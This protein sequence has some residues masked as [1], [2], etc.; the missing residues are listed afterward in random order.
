M[1]NLF[2][3]AVI[4]WVAIPLAAWGDIVQPSGSGNWVGGWTP[5]NGGTYYWDHQSFDGTQCNVGY[6][7]IGQAGAPG[8]PCGSVVPANALPLN[9]AP[10]NIPFWAAN[11]AGSVPV[12][13]FYFSPSNP[14]H[15]VQLEVEIAGYASSNQ[16]YIYFRNGDPS[17]LVFDGSDSA[18]KT[19]SLT[20]TGDFGFYLAAMGTGPDYY[21]ESSKNTSDGSAQ[22]FALFREKPVGTAGYSV[23]D[24]WLGIEDMP[25]DSVHDRDY[26]DMLVRISA[27]PEPGSIVLLGTCLLCAGPIA[28]RIRRRS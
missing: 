26:Q 6:V 8:S 10:G 14:D 4:L 3:A 2:W 15:T 16:L 11:A 20:I 18:P 19:V 22:H 21:T 27:V 24:Y 9:P 23:T 13:D 12:T 1:K 5:S 7:L 17:Q 28:R 25:V